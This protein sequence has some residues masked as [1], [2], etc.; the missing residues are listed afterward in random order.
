MLTQIGSRIRMPLALLVFAVL[1]AGPMLADQTATIVSSDPIHFSKGTGNLTRPVQP[2]EIFHVLAV[3]GDQ[4]TLA[5]AFGFQ[6]TLSRGSVKLID[7][8]PAP[9][10]AVQSTVATN[11]ASKPAPPSPSVATT[12]SA[13]GSGSAGS[14]DTDQ[15]KQLNDAF[16][17]PLF[18][19]SNLWAEDVA[20]VA[21]RLQWP[22]E[23]KT[24]ADASYR[25]YALGKNHVTI[26]DARA[27]SM[28]LYGRDGHPNYLSIV[29]ANQGDFAEMSGLYNDQNRQINVSDDAIT[30]ANE[31]L[32]A[33]VKADAT[34][35]NAQ[36]TAVLGQPESHVFG[37]TADSRVEVHRWDWKGHS[38]LFSTPKDQYATLRIVPSDVADHF[39]DVANMDRDALKA[40]L[41][42]RIDRQDNGDVTITEIPMVDQGPKGYCVPA[43]WE[44]YLRYVDVPADMY[45]L[46]M[47]GNSGMG[48]GTNTDEIRANLND[49][50]ES[51]G[52]RIELADVP[53]DVAHV[54][55]FIDKGLPLMWTCLVTK[56]VEK[57]IDR[58]TT[59]RKTVTDWAAYKQS[60]ADDDKALP[61]VDPSDKRFNGHM[62]MI[63]GYNVRTDELAIS[64]SWGKDFAKR[65]IT[66][67][68]AQTTTLDDLEYVQW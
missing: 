43:T 13:P 10:P 18:A 28:A 68:E 44:R 46:A 24:N 61:P 60:L 26:L 7:A 11:A 14:P 33:A 63:I 47:L 25:K 45:V 38:F 20:A 21:N 34:T 23:S 22:Q 35:I 62:R 19:S 52:R 30:K 39:G 3:N 5:D 56:D 27:Y 4:I 54:S 1:S 55:Q 9:T 16:Q 31:D 17:A 65:W 64:D 49:Y 42:Q 51:Y 66:V 12:S 40:A 6:A 8:A 53:L 57:S 29:F 37:P 67:T 50:V 32:A 59:Q 41:A 58:H 36:L 15:I 48:G 2:D